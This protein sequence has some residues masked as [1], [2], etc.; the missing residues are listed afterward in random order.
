MK[1][2]RSRFFAN[3]MHREIFLL[4][5]W[6]ALIPATIIAIVLYCLIFNVTADQLGIPEAIAYNLIPAAQKIAAILM[7]STPLSILLIMVAAHRIAHKI[8]GP[9][10]RIIAD[11]DS[12]L[13]G[14]S[15]GHIVL[16]KGDKFLPLV[17]RINELLD[18]IR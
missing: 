15:Q 14:K 1:N 5:F 12:R 18:K 7:F 11:I 16:R 8:I 3:K 13:K 17:I 2:K 6:S 10:D 9:F 4:V